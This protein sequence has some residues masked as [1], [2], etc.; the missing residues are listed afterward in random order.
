MCYYSSYT[1]KAVDAQAGDV[2]QVKS[3]MHGTN[4]LMLASTKLV[5]CLRPGTEV[6]ILKIPLL[7]RWICKIQSGIKATF[8]C[9]N[10][11]DRLQRDVFLLA[12]G[13]QVSLQ[14]LPH[15]L[16]MRVTVVAVPERPREEPPDLE[17][18][19]EE[20]EDDLVLV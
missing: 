4:W 17:V 18:W 19:V 15:R 13:Q 8:Q 9:L 20:L 3:Q 10:A 1:A 7:A 12:G 14:Q 16:K 5:A 11:G 6:E 2:L